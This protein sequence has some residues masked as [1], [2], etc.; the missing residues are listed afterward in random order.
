MR[1]PAI[2]LETAAD[3]Y[4][5]LLLDAYGVLVHSS[6]AFEGAAACVDFLRARNVPFWVVTNDASRLPSTAAAT[7][8]D[9]GV[10]VDTDRVLTSGQLLA[11]YARTHGLE[12]ADAAVLGTADSRTYAERAELEI[13]D[14]RSTD[15]EV[16]ILGDDAGFPFRETMDASLTR[17]IRRYDAGSSVRLVVPNPDLIYQRGAESFG[18]AVGAMAEMFET[19]LAERFPEVRPTFDRLGKPHTPIYE[20]A[21]ER[22]GSDHLA[23]IGD[24]LATDIAGANR[25]GLDSILVP[26]GVTNLEAA[27]ETSE[28]RPDYLME[29][30]APSESATT[31]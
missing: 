7:Y 9:S 18:L 17:I 24:Q 11:P 10:D 26:G 3:R 2:D 15:F 27:L 28:V 19:I 20:E 31:G 8:R 13:V 25:A 30:I 23:M 22:A 29:S 16:F 5:G 1:P 6:G 14:P 12:G 4:D 21:V